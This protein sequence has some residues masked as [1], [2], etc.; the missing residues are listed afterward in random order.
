MKILVEVLIISFLVIIGWRQP[1]RDHLAAIVPPQK[2]A[3]WGIVP[4]PPPLRTRRRAEPT[5]APATPRDM[6]WM[7]QPRALDA[8]P[9]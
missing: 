7:W 3:Q 4:E 5:P 1:F 6:S 9:R 2:A 8:P